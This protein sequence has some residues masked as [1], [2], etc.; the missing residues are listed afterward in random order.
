MLLA[1]LD[2]LVCQRTE[3][4]RVV[5]VGAVVAVHVHVPVTVPGAE[6]IER[7]VDGDLLVVP[8]QAVAVGVRV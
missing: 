6:G 7:A 2:R 1:S 3:G 4:G 5:G 8:A